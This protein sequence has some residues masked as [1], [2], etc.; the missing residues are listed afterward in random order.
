MSPVSEGGDK[1][2]PP[3]LLLLVRGLTGRGKESRV[4]SF[5][6]YRDRGCLGRPPCLPSR[7]STVRKLSV[8]PTPTP[9][10]C[11]L[12]GGGWKTSVN[13]KRQLTLRNNIVDKFL[14]TPTFIMYFCVKEVPISTHPHGFYVEDSKSS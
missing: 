8:I 14:L 6:L 10:P 12:G 2:V 4:S 7:T 9:V 11:L 5:S 1:R 13:D 3:S